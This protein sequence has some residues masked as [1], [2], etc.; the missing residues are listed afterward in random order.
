MVRESEIERMVSQAVTTA[1]GL[2]F[3]FVSPGNDGVPDRI[4][5]LPGGR[6]IFAELKTESG[7]LSPVQE[8]QISR[9]RKTGCDCRVIKGKAKAEAFICEICAT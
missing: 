6:V 2:S 5:I 3:K 9:I 8:H 1:G 4:F 7:R